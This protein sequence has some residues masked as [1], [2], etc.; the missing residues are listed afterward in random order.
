MEFH[1]LANLFPM[2]TDSEIVDLGDDMV[3]HGQ[4]KKIMLY[5]GMILDGR[6]RYRACLLK[7]IEPRF[8]EFMGGEDALAYVISMNLMRRNMTAGQRAMTMAMAYPEP[9]VHGKR[10]VFKTDVSSS[11]LSHARTVLA[12]SRAV[13]ETVLNG[14]GSLETAYEAV[15]DRQ[16]SASSLAEDVTDGDVAA[17]SAPAEAAEPVPDEQEEQAISADTP[18]DTVKAKADRAVAKTPKPVPDVTPAADRAEPSAAARAKPIAF[19]PVTPSDDQRKAALR[20]AVVNDNVVTFTP[21]PDG[22]PIIEGDPLVDG[23]GS[24]VDITD[25][26]VG[27]HAINGAMAIID[28]AQTTPEAFW[29]VFGT[30]GRKPDALKRLDS[31][32]RKLAAIKAGQP[33]GA[34][35]ADSKAADS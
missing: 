5:E 31:A 21:K 7:G 22:E 14:T 32:I 23:N 34:A 26:N 29:A 12:D 6:N 19:D 2:M 10:S 3:Q 8:V 30:S 17:V 15:R 35:P 18:A 1:P 11:N 24:A 13:A 16:R 27:A 9:G 4:R 28:L 20:F 25:H 33:E